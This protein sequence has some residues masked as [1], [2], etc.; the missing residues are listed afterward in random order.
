MNLGDPEI[1]SGILVVVVRRREE[2]FQEVRLS[3]NTREASND[4]VG[5]GTAER[6][7]TNGD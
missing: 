6:I 5:K 1:P 4:R 2:G 7:S 3:R